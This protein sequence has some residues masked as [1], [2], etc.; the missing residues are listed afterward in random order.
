[1]AEY[2]G[3]VLAAAVTGALATLVTGW[4]ARPKTK[5]DAQAVKVTAD[6]AMSSEARE[7]AVLWMK[8]AEDAEHKAEE[9]EKRIDELE[10]RVDR[11]V[12]LI[13]SQQREIQ[14]LGGT[15]AIPADLEL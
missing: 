8:K 13:R 12:R 5:A 6:V 9:A 10:R 2:L 11:L 15:V 7:W 4:L 1:M 3:L 14:R